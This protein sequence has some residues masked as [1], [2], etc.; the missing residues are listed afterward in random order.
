M[1]RATMYTWTAPAIAVCTVMRPTMVRS[2]ACAASVL[3][4]A[5]AS[6]TIVEPSISPRG[7]SMPLGS[8]KQDEEGRQDD[9]SR[10]EE[11]HDPAARESEQH[12]RERR[13]AEQG[14]AV[15]RACHCV[16]CGQ[17]ARVA[18]KRRGERR[19]GGTERR[20][21]DR[22]GDREEV[23]HHGRSA[24]QDS[25]TCNGDEHDAREVRYEHH[26]LPAVAISE[27]PGERRCERCRDEARQ[28]HEPDRSLAAD[29][30]RINRDGDQV[31]VVPEDRRGPR[32]LE[33]AQVRVFEDRSRGRT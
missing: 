5:R 13:A 6:D 32:E 12:A 25:E 8:D 30:V 23:D 21:G 22:G 9:Q 7:R 19:L 33:P 29:V 3:K 17:F 15:D 2:G 1:D 26:A 10:G 20:R 16:R 24:E 14:D 11:E 28:E 31:G 18:G 27:H 4:P